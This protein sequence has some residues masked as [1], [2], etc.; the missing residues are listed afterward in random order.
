MA[1]NPRKSQ[2]S[3][4]KKGPGRTKKFEPDLKE[5]AEVCELYCYDKQIF[6]HFDICAETFY[7]FLDRQRYAEEQGTR[8]EFLAAY[9]DGRN[10]GRNFALTSLKKL[11]EKGEVAATIFTA[12]TYGGLLEAKDIKHIELK[13]YEVAFRTKQFLT[14]LGNKFNLNFEELKEFA[15]K[16][17][18]DVKLDVL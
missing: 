18:N 15:D 12:K 10:K 5:W 7:A 16:Y 9:K 3:K 13:K 17:F 1:A 8:S 6:Q 14:E 4:D 2:H 11:T